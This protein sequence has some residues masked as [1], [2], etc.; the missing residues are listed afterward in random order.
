MKGLKR[1]VWGAAL[2]ALAWVPT[3]LAGGGGVSADGYG[4]PAGVI[5]HK[6]T[7][8][9]SA[10]HSTGTLPF[11]GTNL[12]IIVALAVLLVAIGFGMRRFARHN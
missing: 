10:K 7:S 9:A 12:A 6:I 3:A 11:T 5:Q 4:G 2:A 1:A 8:P